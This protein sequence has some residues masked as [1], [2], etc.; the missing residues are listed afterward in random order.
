MSKQTLKIKQLNTNDYI[1]TTK[2]Y[3][4][5]VGIELEGYWYDGHEELKHDSSVEGFSVDYYECNG[6]CRDNCDCEQYCECR[7]CRACDN[8]DNNI[9]EYVKNYRALKMTGVMIVLNL[10]KKTKLYRIVVG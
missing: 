4:E 3:I 1:Q 9:S 5:F 2:N 6:D 10:F 8:C 7:M